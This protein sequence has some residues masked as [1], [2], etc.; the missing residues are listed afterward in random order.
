MEQDTRQPKNLSEFLEWERDR[1]S[2]YEFVDA[3]PRQLCEEHSE[4]RRVLDNLVR[5][6]AAAIDVDTCEVYRRSYKVIAPTI[7]VIPDLVVTQTLT[8][9]PE[10]VL[11]AEVV[12][13]ATASEDRGERWAAFQTLPS[14][15]MYMLVEHTQPR[16]ELFSRERTGWM[17][18]S[19][20]SPGA[21]LPLRQ[22]NVE[23]PMREI[24]GG[25][26]RSAV[27]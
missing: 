14:L 20:L 4:H 10:P 22:P 13:P 7:A 8:R 24:Y 15:L 18:Q 5:L 26:E 19:F 11:I 1:D 23:L 21:V 16:V 25:V 9:F 12:S 17:Y 27:T 2:R 3:C 6:L